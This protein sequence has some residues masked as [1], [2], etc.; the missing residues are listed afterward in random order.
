MAYRFLN[1]SSKDSNLVLARNSFFALRIDCINS[2][3]DIIFKVSLTLSQSLRLSTTD[4]G[5]PSGVVINSTFGNSSVLSNLKPPFS[6]INVRIANHEDF[7]NQEL[8]DEV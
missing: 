8:L 3:L 5:L 2:L 1:T 6:S 7:V 4:L